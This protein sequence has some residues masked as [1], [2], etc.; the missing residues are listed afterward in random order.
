MGLCALFLRAPATAWCSDRS[1]SPVARRADTRK[2]RP[3]EPGGRA[4]IARPPAVGERQCDGQSHSMT[5]RGISSQVKSRIPR[6]TTPQMKESAS[7]PDGLDPQ[8]ITV[9]F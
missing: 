8:K 2:V 9:P 5:G 7:F 3:Y 4:L 6:L 1:T